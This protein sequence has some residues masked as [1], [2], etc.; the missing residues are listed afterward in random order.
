MFAWIR[1]IV[2]TLVGLI[3]YLLY[4]V[5]HSA[6]N[7]YNSSSSSSASSARADDVDVVNI[8]LSASSPTC[9]L[10]ASPRCIDAGSVSEHDD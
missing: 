7:N 6:L 9:L 1:L 3:I 4:G 2:W 5:K 10:P 8:E